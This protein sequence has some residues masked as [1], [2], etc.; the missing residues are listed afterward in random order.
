MLHKKYLM[1]NHFRE[2]S[3]LQGKDDLI[4]RTR[5]TDGRMIRAHFSLTKAHFKR[6]LDPLFASNF[7]LSE[8]FLVNVEVFG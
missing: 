3:K 4:K 2:H 8:T 6:R 7:S 1:I 5:L